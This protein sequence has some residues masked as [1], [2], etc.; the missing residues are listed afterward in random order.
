VR[1][2]DGVLLV[3]GMLGVIALWAAT[4]VWWWLAFVWLVLIVGVLYYAAL[5]V[6]P[7]EDEMTR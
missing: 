1:R 3:T 6:W 7:H 5:F 4:L 2:R